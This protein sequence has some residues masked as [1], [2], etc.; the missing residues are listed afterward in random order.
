[1][2]IEIQQWKSDGDGREIRY[3][4]EGNIAALVCPIKKTELYTWNV[5]DVGGTIDSLNRTMVLGN[6][7]ARTRMDARNA[8]DVLL[9]VFVQSSP[10][11][12]KKTIR[13]IVEEHGDRAR[14]RWRL[15]FD[16]TRELLISA[17]LNE[18]T[19]ERAVAVA[20][21]TINAEVKRGILAK[22][23]A[24]E[25]RRSAALDLVSRLSN[26]LFDFYNLDREALRAALA[27]LQGEARTIVPP[28]SKVGEE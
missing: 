21:E 10:A 14:E 4:S 27:D 3:T 11:G 20:D 19:V 17:R 1:M 2:T 26:R 25:I 22:P 28:P 5:Y 9:Y 8:C 7:T 18:D 13:E 16:K 12:D 23:G 6:G 24:I 15:V